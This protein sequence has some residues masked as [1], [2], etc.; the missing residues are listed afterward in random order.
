MGI[1]KISEARREGVR[2]V[3]SLYG[4]SGGGKTRT[5]LEIAYGM[6]GGDASKIGFLDTENNRGKIYADCLVNEAGQVQRFRHAN[7]DAPFTP[8]RMSQAIL[9]FQAAGVEVLIIDSGS[10]EY[11]GTGGVLEIREPA[12]G[13]HAKRDNIAK[14]EHKKFVNTLLQ[15]DMHV[16]VCLRARE[17]VVIEKVKNPQSG[18][19]ETVYSSLGIQAICEKNFLFEMTASMEIRNGGQERLVVKSGDGLDA[20][21]GAPG[22]HEGKLSREHGEQVRA[23]VE[24]GDQVDPAVE[25]ARNMLRTTTEQGMDALAAAWKALPP[26]LRKAINPQGCPDDLKAAAVAY[27]E[28]RKANADVADDLNAALEAANG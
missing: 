27:D 9:E 24:G 10:H 20:I 6:V 15:S 17:K 19:M 2:I 3:L 14:A 28:M 13:S 25:S 7:L 16:I 18:R 12:P 21:F 5:A 26:K 23:W 4:I 22:F 11:E 1:L 8:S